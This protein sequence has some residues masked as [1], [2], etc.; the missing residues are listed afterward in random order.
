MEIIL[1]KNVV[2]TF[3]L[4]NQEHTLNHQPLCAAVFPKGKYVDLGTKGCKEKG[5]CL[6]S[7]P[8]AHLGNLFFPSPQLYIL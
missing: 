8:M 2:Y 6:L 3:I 1:C 5:L 7:L 4:R